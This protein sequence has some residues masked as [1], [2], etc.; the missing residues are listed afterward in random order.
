MTIDLCCS[1]LD[2]IAARYL[3]GAA[4]LG[5]S[6]K[7]DLVACGDTKG[8]PICGVCVSPTYASVTQSTG[9]ARL[10]EVWIK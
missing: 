6:G 5:E 9:E 1:Q 7:I 4:G 10:L 8:K 3:V 2:R